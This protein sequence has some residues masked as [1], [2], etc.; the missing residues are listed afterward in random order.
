MIPALLTRVIAPAA[1]LA[2]VVACP[3][4]AAYTDPLDTPASLSQLASKTQL[5][6]V[7]HAGERLV[8]VGW[9]GHIIYS[10]D[11]GRTWLQANSPVDIDLTAVTFSSAQQGWAVGHGGVILH[12]TDA[13]LTWVKQLDGRDSGPLMLAYYEQR[14]KEG[15]PDAEKY[16]EDVRLNTEG[17]AEQP[18]LDALFLDDLH[19][20]VVGTFNQIMYTADGGRSWT[21]QLDLVDNPE[22]LHLNAITRQGNTLYIAS[23][24][25]TIFRKTPTDEHFVPL[26]TGYN[27]TLFNVIAD[28]KRIFALGLRGTLLRS[29][30][31][32]VTWIKVDTDAD[33]ALTSGLF[34]EDG[35]VLVTSQA[36][37]LFKAGR[38]ETVFHSLDIKRPAM[39]TALA[40]TRTSQVVV[41]GTSGANLES[42]D[43]VR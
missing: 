43:T 31:D 25:G 26:S 40:P 37:Q 24:R 10:D 3:V 17:G 28:G 5:M 21:P 34:L 22:S 33:T 1:L 27:G 18:W 35:S 32:G 38:G 19:G 20:Y 15:A 9:R 7:T 41:V 2:T 23:E 39:F 30:D 13:G 14:L 16:I 11:Q 36:G 6:D 12:T 29:D 8:A 42:V 4:M